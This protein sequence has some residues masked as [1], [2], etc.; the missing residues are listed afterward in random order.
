[1][2]NPAS[3]PDSSQTMCVPSAF[4]CWLSPQGLSVGKSH[5]QARRQVRAV[6]RLT[7][8]LS[9]NSCWPCPFRHANV[10]LRWRVGR[11]VPH[12]RRHERRLK[13][14]GVYPGSGE[15]PTHIIPP[16]PPPC[17]G[18]G[19]TARQGLVGGESPEI[20]KIHLHYLDER[21][22]RGYP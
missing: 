9:A 7:C 6:H 21:R 1:V 15:C 12:F 14:P 5:L 20:F 11:A 3:Q 16:P 18:L 2:S 8:D 17:K 19:V 22:P 4:N 13:N 10:P